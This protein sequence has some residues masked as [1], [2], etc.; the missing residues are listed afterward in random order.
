MKTLILSCNTGGGHKSVPGKAIAEK[1]LIQQGDEAYVMDYLTL[2]RGR[3]LS[4]W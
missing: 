1:T 2:A 3:C 4:N